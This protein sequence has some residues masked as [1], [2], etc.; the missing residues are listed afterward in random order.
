MSYKPSYLVNLFID[1]STDVIL[2]FGVFSSQAT[3]HDCSNSSVK[4]L[5]YS[6]THCVYIY[7]H[8]TVSCC[9]GIGI[10]ILLITSLFS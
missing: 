10:L 4:L 6:V 7:I 1:S 2:L 8:V 9:V 3:F 5:L